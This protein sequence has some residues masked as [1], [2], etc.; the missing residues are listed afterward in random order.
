M[1]VREGNREEDIH[2]EGKED[3]GFILARNIATSYV[4]IPENV[5]DSTKRNILDA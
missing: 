4:D 3:I 5:V 1:S 2:M